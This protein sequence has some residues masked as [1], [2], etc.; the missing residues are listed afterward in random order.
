M[1]IQI[2]VTDSDILNGQRGSSTACPV[3]WAIRRTLSYGTF[4]RVGKTTAAIGGG[5][6]T[7]PTAAAGFVRAFDF[8]EPVEPF[9]F[10]IDL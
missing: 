6:V 3:A 8:G 4:I 5:Y 1:R 2:H 10:E 7:L 9:S